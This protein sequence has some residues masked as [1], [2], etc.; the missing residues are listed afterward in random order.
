LSDG[1]IDVETDADGWRNGR[2]CWTSI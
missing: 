1:L 2:N